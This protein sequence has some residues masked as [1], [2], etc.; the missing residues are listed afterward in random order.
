MIGSARGGRL[1]A[2]GG[3]VEVFVIVAADGIR[4]VKGIGKI[5]DIDAEKTGVEK[6]ETLCVREAWEVRV[7]ICLLYTSRC[8]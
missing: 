7:I 2:L 8:V 6:E 4:S 5:V 1:G 3:G